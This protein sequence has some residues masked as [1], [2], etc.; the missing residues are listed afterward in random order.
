MGSS[1]TCQFV[2]ERRTVF[3]EF[4]FCYVVPDR[5]NDLFPAYSSGDETVEFVVWPPLGEEGFGKDDD[6]KTAGRK[7]F[8]YLPTEA[9]SNFEFEFV[10][11]Y[12]KTAALKC[13]CEGSRYHSLVLGR[14]RYEDIELPVISKWCCCTVGARLH[15]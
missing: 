7:A 10:V 1:T 6:T 13:P 11:P 2:G 12:P 4:L 14:M 8:V 15:E 3:D 9:I 5:E